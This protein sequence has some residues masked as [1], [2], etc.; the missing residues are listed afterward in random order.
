MVEPSPRESTHAPRTALPFGTWPSA[1]TAEAVAAAS[2]RLD[3]ARFVGDEIWWAE[4]VPEERGR[5]AVRRLIGSPGSAEAVRTVLPAPWNARSRVHEYGG[6]AWDATPEGALVFVERSDQRVWLL[7]PGSEPVP[8]TPSVA[9]QSLGGLRVSRGRLLAVREIS[10]EVTLHDIVEI[11]LDGSAADDAGRIVSL[12]AGSDFVAQPALSPDGST[13]AWLAWDHPHMPW[14]RAE[15]RVRRLADDQA[16]GRRVAGGASAALQPEWTADGALLVCDDVTGFWNIHRVSASGDRSEAVAPD[17]RDTGGPLWVL[18][19]RWFAPLVDGGVAAVRTRGRDELVHISSDGEVTAVAVPAVGNVLVEDARGTEVLVSGSPEDAPAGLWHVDLSDPTHP[20]IRLL[21]GGRWEDGEFSSW[22]PRPRRFSVEGRH[23][24]VHAVDFPPTHPH[25]AGPV[26]ALPPYV[27]LVH[28]GPTAHAPGVVSPKTLFLTS[29]GIGVVEVNYGGSSGFGRDY[30]ERLRGRWGV[31]DVDDVVDIAEALAA[32]GVADPAHIAIA[33]GS[34][35][36][37][38]VLGALVA[39]D[40]FGAGIS[41][42]G[43]ADA[44]L[45][46]AETH[47]FEARYLDGL[48]GPLPDSEAVY[49]ERSPL[50]HADRITAP[51][52]LLQGDEDAVVPPSQSEAIRDALRA[53]GVPHAYVLYPGEGHGFRRSETVVDMVQKELAFLGAAFGFAPADVP[54]LDLGSTG[55]VDRS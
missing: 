12:T 4:T 8:L 48:I 7:T 20:G 14:D 51:V 37:W 19:S 30:R 10:G 5:T 18:G 6:G 23:G 35:G 47:D 25:V 29:R 40:V 22:V 33:G 38:T 28:G 52:L 13:L 27:V 46:A 50:T 45:L 32:D 3:G 17:D 11:P 41:R 2:P 36:G 31:V 53:G 15:V 49:L 44:R 34:A 16:A 21:T 42:Y 54:P 1:I 9:G 26:T 55:P 39:S 43:V 24:T